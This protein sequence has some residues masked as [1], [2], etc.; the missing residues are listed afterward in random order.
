MVCLRSHHCQDRIPCWRNPKCADRGWTSTK[1][2]PSAAELRRSPD[3]SGA[4]IQR[5]T[6]MP[7]CLLRPRTI[8]CRSSQDCRTSRRPADHRVR[9]LLAKT[10]A[11]PLAAVDHRLPGLPSSG[12]IAMTRSG[13]TLSTRRQRCTVIAAIRS[14]EPAVRGASYSERGG[15]RCLR[16]FAHSRDG[17]LSFVR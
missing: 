10:S 2:S 17:R 16:L 14:F 1:T 5:S 6:G 11:P 7:A 9:D 13:T 15:R 12:R 3:R 8:H 4:S